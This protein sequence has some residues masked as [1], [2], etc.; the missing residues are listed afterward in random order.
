MH[1]PAVSLSW[2]AANDNV[3]VAS[4]HVYRNGTLVTTT[5]A[6]SLVDTGLSGATAYSYYVVAVDASGNVGGP[7][8]SVTVTTRKK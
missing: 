1:G 3:G 8:P 4:Y 7:S 2:A 6:T 5:P